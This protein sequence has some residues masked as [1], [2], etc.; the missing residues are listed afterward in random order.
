MPRTGAARTGRRPAASPAG[1]DEPTL[2]A[3]DGAGERPEVAGANVVPR[4]PEGARVE[5]AAGPL[6][7]VVHHPLKAHPLAV[8]RGVDAGDAVVVELAHLHPER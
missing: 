2:D 6:E 1:V 8:L 4:D 7:H 5:S 3:G